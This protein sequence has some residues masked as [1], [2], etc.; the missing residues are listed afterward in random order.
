MARMAPAYGA[1]IE[2]SDRGNTGVK[3][4]LQ[5]QT[6]ESLEVPLLT[7]RG[8]FTLDGSTVRDTRFFDA[9]PGHTIAVGEILEFANDITFMQPR[10]LAVLTN[11]I[12]IDTQFNHSYSDGDTFTSASDDMRVD[13]FAAPVV[14]SILPSPTQS[15]DITRFILTIEST[16]NSMDFTEFGSINGLTVGCVMRIK[17]ANGDFRN[18]FNFKTNGEFIEKSF[19]HNF[20][21]KTGGG[22]SGFVARSTYAGPEKR[23]VAIRVDGALGEELQCVINDNLSVGLLKFHIAAQGHELSD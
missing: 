1:P 7:G 22:G 11:N 10:V 18:L 13:G 19:D 16:A 4:F 8:S 12:E 14:F 21:I 17:R 3:T 2:T 20:Q 15:G 5:D 9:M 23:G 6:S